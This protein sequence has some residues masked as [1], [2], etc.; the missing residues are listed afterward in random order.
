MKAAIAPN[1]TSRKRKCSF[2]CEN[3]LLSTWKERRFYQQ[4]LFTNLFVGG[5]AEH[6]VLSV[7]RIYSGIDE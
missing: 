2:W 5:I 7:R 4:N 6:E 3:K 1:S